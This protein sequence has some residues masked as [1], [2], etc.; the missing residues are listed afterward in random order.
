M[1]MQETYEEDEIILKEKSEDRFM[2]LVLEGSVA[3]Y[4]N[5]RKKDEYLLGVCN[6]GNTFGEMGL[7]CHEENMYT[8]VAFSKATV[9][10]FSEFE[11]G[12]FIRGYPDQAL[13]LMSNIARMNKVL[14]INLKMVL[15][16]N[17]Q[18]ELYKKMY[19]EI[20][21]SN[22]EKTEKGPEA[23]PLKSDIRENGAKWHIKRFGK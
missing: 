12:S 11:L 2:Y 15:E 6:K 16:D 4:M 17:Q 13:G 1:G 20:M 7:L 14:N 21:A 23:G 3:L 9:A 22:A 18:L 19:S 5:Y 8:A 10:M